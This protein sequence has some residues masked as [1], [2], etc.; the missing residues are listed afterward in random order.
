VLTK[1]PG[2]TIHPREIAYVATLHHPP[3]VEFSHSS[4]NLP[5]SFFLEV[6]TFSMSMNLSDPLSVTTAVRVPFLRFVNEKWRFVWAEYHAHAVVW[7]SHALARLRREST[8]SDWARLANYWTKHGVTNNLWAR[9]SRGART[10]KRPPD[11][12][13]G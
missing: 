13:M 3:L 7:R 11:P 10:H 8:M 6:S 4:M 9:L 5:W 1:F 12:E 2:G